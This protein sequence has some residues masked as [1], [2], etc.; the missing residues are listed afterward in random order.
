MHGTTELIESM[1]IF[2]R[3]GAATRRSHEMVATLLER[4]LT[5]LRAHPD[6][7]GVQLT[8][9]Y[10]DPTESSAL[11]DSKQLERAIYNLLLNGCQSARTGEKDPRVE[12][13]LGLRD[14]MIVIE[15]Q[16]NGPGVPEN[17]R[18][19]MFQPFVS[20]GKQKGSG[21]GLT[22]ATLRCR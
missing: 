1:L 13:R 5:L 12:A 4:A 14:D 20:E 21:L 7:A 18:N 16:D 15:V 19:S 3:T 8:T 22:L 17:I 6:A 11:V 2:S 10:S 9:T